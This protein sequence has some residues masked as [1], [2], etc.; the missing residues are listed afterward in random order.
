M[1]RIAL[2]NF[3]PIREANIEFGDLTVLVGTQASGKSLFVQLVKA[4]EDAGAIRADLKSYGFDW[5][6]GENVVADYCSLYFGGGLEQLVQPDTVIVRDGRAINFR[7]IAKPGG[8]SSSVETVFLVPAQRVLVLQDGWPKPFMAYSAGD[9]YCMRRFS[10]SLRVLMEQGVGP[11]EPIFPQPRRLKAELKQLVDEAIYLGAK[12]NLE[13][14]GMRKRITLSP[15]DDAASLPYSAWS[16][17][18]REFTPLLLGLYWLMPAAKV[19]RRGDLHTVIIEEPEMGLH[20]Q[21]IVTFGLLLF[22]LMQRG[23]RVIVSTHS[24]VILDLIWAI[25]ELSETGESRAMKALANIFGIARL[26]NQVRDIFRA[27]LEKTHRVYFFE[28]TT[29]GI[30]ARD[31]SSLDPG[32]EDEAVSGWGGLSGFSG[33]IAE[34][35]GDALATKGA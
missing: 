31:I 34:V 24:P 18:Q 5:L 20:P 11:G 27:A 10:D 30:V 1:K 29:S 23:Y 26:S 12:L 13:T 7:E 4:L 8:R 35:V 32:A 25:R 16:A 19:A 6:H 17:G 21:A 3:G 28:R 22:E 14:E 15:R 33:R 2:K 9:P